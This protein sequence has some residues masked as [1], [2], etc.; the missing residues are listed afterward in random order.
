MGDYCYLSNLLIEQENT[1]LSMLMS[2]LVLRQFKLTA[3]VV[4]L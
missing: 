3:M 2:G 1:P 4:Y